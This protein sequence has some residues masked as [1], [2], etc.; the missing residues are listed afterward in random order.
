MEA[1]TGHMLATFATKVLFIEPLGCIGTWATK[2][3]STMLLIVLGCFYKF[4]GS[5]QPTRVE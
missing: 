1:G 3:E 2:V 5:L 4:S